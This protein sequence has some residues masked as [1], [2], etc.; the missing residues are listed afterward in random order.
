MYL[1]GTDQ[2]HLHSNGKST[3]L[4]VFTWKKLGIFHGYVSLPEGITK[5]SFRALSLS[6]W[7]C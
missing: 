4:M 7:R 2:L 5:I 3:I 6:A 1:A